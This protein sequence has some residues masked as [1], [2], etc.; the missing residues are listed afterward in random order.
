MGTAIGRH[1]SMGKGDEYHCCARSYGLPRW[2]TGVDHSQPCPIEYL[3]SHYGCSYYSVVDLIL[4]E[5]SEKPP[6]DGQL[7]KLELSTVDTFIGAVLAN[8]EKVL[9][10]RGV[11]VSVKFC[12]MLLYDHP[13]KALENLE[14]AGDYAV[15][16]RWVGNMPQGG[17]TILNSF[18]VEGITRTRLP[19]GTNRRKHYETLYNYV[20]E[21]VPPVNIQQGAQIHINFTAGLSFPRWQV[22]WLNYRFTWIW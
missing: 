5:A 10:D 11:V 22:R 4:E 17:G 16:T 12:K 3:I 7:P 1:F 18:F 6:V 9:K 21:T 19:L 14:Q 13:L 2:K 15:A 8:G 20:S